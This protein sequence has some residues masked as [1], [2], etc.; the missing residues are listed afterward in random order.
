MS[1]QQFL[2]NVKDKIGTGTVNE[3][4]KFNDLKKSMLDK[5]KSS[6]TTKVSGHAVSYSSANLSEKPE[7]EETGTHVSNSS[8][9]EI[10]QEPSKREDLKEKLRRKLKPKPDKANEE[11][12]S[13]LQK[14]MKSNKKETDE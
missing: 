8:F 9:H 4:N 14:I 5:N 6:V 1:L 11:A 2:N 3:K 13:K 10:K 7:I 12:M